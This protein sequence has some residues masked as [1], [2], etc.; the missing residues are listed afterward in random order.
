MKKKFNFDIKLLVNILTV[1]AF[2]VAIIL[3]MIFFNTTPDAISEIDNRKL[4]ENPFEKED[5]DLTNNIDNYISDRIGF[6]DDIITG[7][8]VLNDK[9]F[10]KMTHPYYTY[11]KDGYV[12]GA[13]VSTVNDF[14][15]YH[16]AFADMVKSLQDYCESRGVPFLFVFNPAKPAI[17]QDKLSDGVNYNRQWVDLFMAELDKRNINYLDNTVTM[18]QLRQ[19]GINGY[20]QKWDANHWNDTGAYYGVQKIQQRLNERVPN[21]H[22]NSEEDYLFYTEHVDTLLISKFP[23]DEDVPLALPY[24]QYRECKSDYASLEVS[25]QHRTFGY[26]VNDTR[27]A[28]GCAKGLVF[29]GSYMNS[30]GIKYMLNSFGEYAYVHDYQNVINLPYYFNIFQPDCVVFEVAEY[31]FNDSY[32]RYDDMKKIDYNPV[33]SSLSEEQYSLLATPDIV[34]VEKNGKLTKITCNID[35]TFKYVWAELD[36][37]IYDMRKVDGG[38]QVTVQT[39]QVDSIKDNIKLYYSN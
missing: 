36:G 6:R 16:I 22:V 23:I 5:G 24:A 7:Y 4:A 34:E 37:K 33:F 29:Q 38:Y 10:N 39:E 2:A 12:F 32:F 19:E 35:A 3:P 21:V 20:N 1:L 25:S 15:D 11:G 13:G 18:T 8:M 9:L 26:I 14:G 27:Q 28:E 17:Y 30:A 31:T